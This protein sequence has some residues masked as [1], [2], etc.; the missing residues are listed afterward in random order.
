MYTEYAVR[1]A[2]LATIGFALIAACYIFFYA[3][4]NKELVPLLIFYGVLIAN[5]FFSIRCFASIT[6]SKNVPQQLLDW[7]L[8]ALFFSIRCF[9][10]IT[11]SKNVPQQLL[12][13]TLGALMVL[14]ALTLDNASKFTFLAALLFAVA[15]YK[16]VRLK[17]L[18]G[19][20]RLLRRKIVIDSWGLLACALAYSGIFWG[21]AFFTTWLW[22]ISFVLANVYLFFFRPLYKLP[23]K[24]S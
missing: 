23:G 17:S 5:T 14:L 1:R 16:Y 22:A 7:T 15:T 20:R 19:Q 10:S 8:G 21:N 2:I 6:P 24:I 3:S 11:P 12:D 18:I 4:W 13:W 9:A